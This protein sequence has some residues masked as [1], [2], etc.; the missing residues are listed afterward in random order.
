MKRELTLKEQ[1]E[2]LELLQIHFRILNEELL[3][4]MFN[5]ENYNVN[6][7]TQD[8]IETRLYLLLSRF[9][10]LSR[11][12]CDDED[13]KN[14][15]DC[16]LKNIDTYMSILRSQGFK[17]R[18]DIKFIISI[19]EGFAKDWAMQKYFDLNKIN[20]ITRVESARGIDFTNANTIIMMGE[21]FDYPENAPSLTDKEKEKF[22]EL[23]NL[24]NRRIEL[25]TYE[26]IESYDY[27]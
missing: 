22:H 10:F 8:V 7:L 3:D 1:E 24:V 16:S 15:I 19:K 27:N 14:K 17:K 26:V 21:D 12:N 4:F 6:V 18:D 9:E 13:I 2:N 5:L 20:I 25:N 11:F 23:L